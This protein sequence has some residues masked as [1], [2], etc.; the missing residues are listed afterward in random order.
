M[1]ILGWNKSIVNFQHAHV[2][3][4]DVKRRENKQLSYWVKNQ[5]KLYC[6]FLRYEH[7][8]PTPELKPALENIGFIWMVEKGSA[9]KGPIRKKNKIP[10]DSKKGICAFLSCIMVSEAIPIIMMPWLPDF[11]GFHFTVESQKVGVGIV[12][13]TW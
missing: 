8:L 10:D 4:T 11:S 1:N 3:I 9:V 2:G 6:Q 12:P 5:R 7:T 13:C